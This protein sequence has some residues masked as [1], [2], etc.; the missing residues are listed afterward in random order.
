MDIFTRTA[1][2][3]KS[4]NQYKNIND[5]A[6]FVKEVCRFFG[7]LMTETVRT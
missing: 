7:Y 5:S 3:V 6:S 4:Y 1:D 2:I